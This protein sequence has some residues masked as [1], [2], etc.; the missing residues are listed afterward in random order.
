MQCII[1]GNESGRALYCGRKCRN[2]R[3]NK[4][5]RDRLISEIVAD[6]PDDVADL[7]KQIFVKYGE[8]PARLAKQVYHL[9]LNA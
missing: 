1:C 9:A 7:L 6:A 5:R 3:A 8:G 4:A 2:H